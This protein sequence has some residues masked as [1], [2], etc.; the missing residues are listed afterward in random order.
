VA[1]S[2]GRSVPGAFLAS[3]RGVTG[4]C[5]GRGRLGA[6]PSVGCWRRGWAGRTALDVLGRL[7]SWP[8]EGGSAGLHGAPVQ[9]ARRLG[10]GHDARELLA[11]R[12]GRE[13]G[14]ESRGRRENR[15]RERDKGAASAWGRRQQGRA[16]AGV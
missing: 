13:Q 15:G 5:S 11:A 4:R 12:R 7:G 1:R 3:G 10:T 16:R 2:L 6:R 9:G 8:G 14:E